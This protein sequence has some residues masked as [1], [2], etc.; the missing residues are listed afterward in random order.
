M[1]AIALFEDSLPDAERLMLALESWSK[2][3][4]KPVSL[5]HF[6]AAGDINSLHAYDCI[7]LD[8]K[9]PGIS[10]MEFARNIRSSGILVPIIFVSDHIEYSV[11]GY[12]V[13]AI[14]FINK[15][16]SRFEEKLFECMDKTLFEIENSLRS[17]YTIR[18]KGKTISVSL[19]EVLYFEVC[20]HTI[21]I[22]TFSGILNER[23]KLSDLITELPDQFVRCSRSF[24]VN[25]LHIKELTSRSLLL[26]N[27]ARLS[28]SKNHTD[29]LFKT[30]LRFH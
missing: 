24:V 26:L 11:E 16:D 17:N 10:G 6:Y 25:V 23:K 8:V 27:G 21:S 1:T 20:N 15:N 13:N 12:E 22:Y 18:D 7:M 29:E 9:M 28:I 14:R 3:R 2:S 19:S 5:K 4:S 30:Y